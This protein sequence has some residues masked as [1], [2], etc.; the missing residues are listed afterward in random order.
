[1]TL[2][3]NKAKPAQDELLTTREAAKFLKMSVA[4]FEQD[5]WAASTSGTPPKIPYMKLG[6]GGKAPVRYKRS[7]LLDFVNRGRVA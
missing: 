2:I 7:D 5:R 6:S 4:W 1:M 3:F